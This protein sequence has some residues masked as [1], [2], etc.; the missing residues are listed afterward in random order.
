MRF[1]GAAIICGLMGTAPAL[2][3]DNGTLGGVTLSQGE[4]IIQSFGAQPPRVVRVPQ[5]RQA[6]KQPRRVK[7]L[8]PVEIDRVTRKARNQAGWTGRASR[9]AAVACFPAGTCARLNNN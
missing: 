8:P 6:Q 5:H 4:T 3:S 2:A 7:R 1:L 9:P